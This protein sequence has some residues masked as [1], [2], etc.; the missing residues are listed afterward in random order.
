MLQKLNLSLS[1]ITGILNP[2][3]MIAKDPQSLYPAF[4]IKDLPKSLLLGSCGMPGNTAYFGFLEICKPKSG[5]T[6]VVNGA[7]GAVGSLVG[8]LAKLAGCRVV[9]FAGS[10]EKCQ[11]LRN[12]LGFDKVYNYKMVSR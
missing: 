9:A 6:V 4:D 5:E 12:D 7:A 3:E 10:D 1:C 11:Y 8:Q 2:K